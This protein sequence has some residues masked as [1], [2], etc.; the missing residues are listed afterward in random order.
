MKCKNLILFA[1]VL[2]IATG[3]VSLLLYSPIFEIVASPV[4]DMVMTFD[5]E[6]LK[7]RLFAGAAFFLLGFLLVN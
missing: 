1:P 6:E 2:G 4:S 3:A 7:Y 5:R